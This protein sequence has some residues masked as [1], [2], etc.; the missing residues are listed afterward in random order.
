[1]YT[2]LYFAIKQHNIMCVSEISYLTHWVNSCSRYLCIMYNGRCFQGIPQQMNGS[3]CGVFT[4][5]YAEYISRGAEITFTQVY[6]FHIIVFHEKK[7]VNGTKS[8]LSVFN[9]HK[10]TF[11]GIYIAILFVGTHAILQKANGV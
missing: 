9:Q 4:C 7:C 3:D 10:G 6:P 5:K 8:K 11:T 2:Y 1:M